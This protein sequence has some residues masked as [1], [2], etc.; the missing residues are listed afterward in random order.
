MGAGPAS[1]ALNA[2]VPFIN[3]R[4]VRQRFLKVGLV[5][6]DMGPIDRGSNCERGGTREHRKE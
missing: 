2:T 6:F 4:H 5:L 3:S 1:V